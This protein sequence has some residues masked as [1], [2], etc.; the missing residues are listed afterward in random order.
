MVEY[1]GCTGPLGAWAFSR[2]SAG[3]RWLFVHFRSPSG[4]R[5][6]GACWHAGGQ[7]RADGGQLGC[8]TSPCPSTVALYPQRSSNHQGRRLAGAASSTPTI[9]PSRCLKL[10]LSAYGSCSSEFPSGLVGL[11]SLDDGSQASRRRGIRRFQTPTN[12]GVIWRAPAGAVDP[13]APTL[14]PI[15]SSRR[16]VRIR[17]RSTG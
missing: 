5:T 9:A 11:W 2:P 8:G 16:Q 6:C 17:F 4:S 14:A 15:R 1:G 13:K 7:R 10:P 3:R 12:L